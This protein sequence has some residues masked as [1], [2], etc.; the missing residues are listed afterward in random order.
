MLT[1]EDT[2]SLIENRMKEMLDTYGKKAYLLAQEILMLQK[3]IS[4]EKPTRMIYLSEWGKYYSRPTVSAM[5]NLIARR[6][7]N[8]FNKVCQKDGKLWL[9]NEQA[10]LA[11]RDQRKNEE[12]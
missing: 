10:Y 12:L 8:G 6:S 9:I 3:S 2:N 7:D 1:I 11:W 4:Q 5:R